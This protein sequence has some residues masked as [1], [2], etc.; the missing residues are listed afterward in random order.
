METMKTIT[1]WKQFLGRLL[2]TGRSPRTK[3]RFFRVLYP[4]ATNFAEAIG[5]SRDRHQELLGIVSQGL[6]SLSQGLPRHQAI[7]VLYSRSEDLNEFAFMLGCFSF[8]EGVMQAERDML[9]LH[10]N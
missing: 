9:R 6:R 1:T 4:T 8:N 10:E 5:L 3:E 2:A 7:E